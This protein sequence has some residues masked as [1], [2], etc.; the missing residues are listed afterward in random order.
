MVRRPTRRYASFALAG[1]LL[2]LLGVLAALQYRWIGELS[3]A[4]RRR[5]EASLESSAER[6]AADFDLEITRAF[7]A[8]VLDPHVPPA[9]REARLRERHA[10]WLERAGHPRL[11]RELL[12]ASR[13]DDGEWTLRRF[14]AAARGFQPVAWPD[15]LAPLRAAL[16]EGPG[17]PRGSAR[18]GTAWPV[19]GQ[20]PAL[21]VPAGFAEGSPALVLLRLDRGYMA[22]TLLPELAARH[23][24]ARD[25]PAYDVAVV[26]RGD[27]TDVIYR[28]D[29]GLRPADMRPA[30]VGVELLAVRPSPELRGLH[31]PWLGM[32]GGEEVA[33]EG[34]AGPRPP[35]D[36]RELRTRPGGPGRE[37]PPGAPARF[38]RRAYEARGGVWLLLARPRGGSLEAL[39]ARTRGRNLALSLGVLSLLGASVIFLAASTRRA[40]ALARQQMEFVAG[41]T[42]ELHTPLAG[43]RSAAQNL[44]DGV[45]AE[46][47]QVR[48][49]GGLIEKESRRLSDML[50]QVLDFAG[51]RSG[52]RALRRRR[53]EPRPLIEEALASC[54]FLIEERGV[55]VQAELAPSLPALD[56]DPD[57]LRAALRNLIQNAAKYGGGAV[58]IGAEARGGALEVRVEDRGPGIAA[59]DRARIFEPFY[60]GENATAGQAPGS[61]LGLSIVKD[62]IEAHGGR[63]D[64]RARPEGGSCFTLR[65]PAASGHTPEAA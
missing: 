3:R 39:V 56:A 35:R 48:R 51:I 46:P 23:F 38:A 32:R 12:L 60:R 7:A 36:E 24:G 53:V 49:Y 14:E 42:H 4:E 18:R 25:E 47:D 1:A 8:F 29:P 27:P 15:D 5:L 52:R 30:A 33:P 22:G 16:D 50:Q 31:L 57:A 21:V 34:A 19:W 65:L 41:V 54:R 58:L 28:S 40:H 44:K 20:D 62:V 9:E 2:L 10:Q 17:W 11:L 59:A 26:R 37:R 55:S 13:G 64:V 45:V 63:V 61:G 6:F 43:I